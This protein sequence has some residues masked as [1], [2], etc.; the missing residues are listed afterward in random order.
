MLLHGNRLRIELGEKFRKHG[1][2]DPRQ[3]ITKAGVR[4]L[5]KKC[6][7]AGHTEIIV[8]GKNDSQQVEIS[9]VL[10]FQEAEELEK[11]RYREF[12]ATH[13]ILCIELDQVRMNPAIDDM[14]ILPEGRTHIKVQDLPMDWD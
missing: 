2:R 8:L 11:T 4:K 13:G 3:L 1:I 7:S 5:G 14:P 10:F 6:Y 9:G 12:A